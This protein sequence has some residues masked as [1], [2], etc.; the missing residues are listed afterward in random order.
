MA[1]LETES[2]ARAG[3]AVELAYGDD[4][5]SFP[6]WWIGEST[7]SRFGCVSRDSRPTLLTNPPTRPKKPSCL[8]GAPIHPS[9]RI[10]PPARGPGGRQ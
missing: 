8:A 10:N 9:S 6:G 1:E 7:A 3:S 5:T 4:P 2:G